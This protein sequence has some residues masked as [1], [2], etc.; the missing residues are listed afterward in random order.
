MEIAAEVAT[1]QAVWAIL[2][3]ALAGVVIRELH[4]ENLKRESDLIARYEVN[5]S[6]SKEQFNTYRTESKERENKLMD[7]LSRS[8]ESQ[9]ITALALQG[10]NSNLSA[11][12]GRVDRIEK[13]SFKN[14]E[15]V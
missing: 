13:H 1:S 5:Q 4:K 9:E 8:N 6:E 10:I 15:E 7:H 2:C 11:L 14:R 12:E 3:I